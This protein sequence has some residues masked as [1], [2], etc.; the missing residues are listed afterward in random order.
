MFFKSGI[1]KLKALHLVHFANSCFE[2]AACVHVHI[3][4]IEVLLCEYLCWLIS[5]KTNV[6]RSQKHDLS[7]FNVFDCSAPYQ[8]LCPFPLVSYSKEHRSDGKLASSAWAALLPTGLE[9]DLFRP[10]IIT[11]PVE[12]TFPL[13]EIKT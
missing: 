1:C 9:T 10:E 3:C 7:L 8:D 4:I 12:V 2:F 11:G 13:W 5:C 6:S